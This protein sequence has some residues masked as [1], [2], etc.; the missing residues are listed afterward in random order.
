MEK[1][2]IGRVVLVF[3]LGIVVFLALS[4][5]PRGYFPSI[6]VAA[7]DISLSFL[8]NSQSSLS[9]CEA[10]TG[11]VA[12]VTLDG[13]PLC[14]VQKLRCDSALMPSE[15]LLLTD[16]PL[17]I[18]S[19]RMNNGVVV[20]NSTNASLALSACQTSQAISATS[21]NPIQ[22]FPPKVS[23]PKPSAHSNVSL[24][25]VALLFSALAAAWFTSWLIIRYEHLHAHFSH[26]HVD[27][28]PQKHHC[29]PTPR[30][31]G[32]AI[33]AGLIAGGA[34]MLFAD[35][36]PAE[37]DFG[38]LLL[39]ALP[40]FL[41]GLVEDVTKK[42]GVFERLLCTMLASG[43]A[44]W[45][46]GAILI[47]LDIPVVDPFLTWGALAIGLTIFAIAGVANAINILDGYNGLVG[48]FSVIA[49]AAMAWVANQIGDSLVFSVAITLIGAILGFL[50]WNWPGGR[51]FLGDG[52]AYIIGFFLGELSVLLVVR[53]PE[54]SP[55][56]PLLMLIHPVIETCFSIFRRKVRA[57]RSPGEPDNEHLHQLVYRKIGREGGT[58]LSHNSRVAK[59]FW[60][61]TASIAVLGSLW[62][63][64]TEVLMMLALT[65]C[66]A[67]VVVYI[68]LAQQ[69]A[70]LGV[71]NLQD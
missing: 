42:V 23:R 26:D 1:K 64:S 13:C 62:W 5:P 53:N 25:H 8:F 31:G 11:N 44:G 46:M 48:G 38:L 20:F 40:A 27:S 45:L 67:Y 17:N 34:V 36:I 10:L 28:G 35:A 39:A 60:G 56:F 29:Q 71:R 41:G 47:R 37:H 68:S 69:P 18:P 51:I 70:K 59:F 33:K 7:G 66:L 61:A 9:A 21:K 6:E 4:Q 63:R 30:I 43:V 52:G 49:L 12:R 54:V 3:L 55:W 24:W 22:C 2:T 19:G 50:Y 58:R 65:Y 15:Q 57:G 16:G 14:L 32:L